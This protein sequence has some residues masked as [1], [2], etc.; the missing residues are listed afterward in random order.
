[1]RG[2]FSYKDRHM[3]AAYPG[4]YNTF[5]PNMAASGGLEVDFSRNVNDFALPKYVQYVTTQKN[6]GRYLE[7]TIEEAGRLLNVDGADV[8]WPDGTISP[9]GIGNT[10]SFEF[11]PF[12]TKRR[13]F[14]FTMGE[15]AAEQAEFDI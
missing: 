13:V 14:S 15:L 12:T 10:E 9:K 8:E 4:Q 7:M 6:V 2:L 11:K 5:I 1:M 3:A